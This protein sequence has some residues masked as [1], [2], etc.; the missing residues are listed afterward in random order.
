MSCCNNLTPS[1]VV[2]SRTR[3]ICVPSILRTRCTLTRMV[4][5]I[6]AHR[7]HVIAYVTISTVTGICCIT[8]FLTRRS[9]HIT[10]IAMSCCNNLTPSTVVTSRTCLVCVPTDFRTRRSLSLVTYFVMTERKNFFRFKRFTTYC[11]FFMF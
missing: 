2:T 3:F 6:M 10:I 8:I 1:T 4:Y 9:R 11:T 5:V 7:I